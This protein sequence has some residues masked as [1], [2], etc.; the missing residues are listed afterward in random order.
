VFS[1]LVLIV[2][3]EC[4]V[5]FRRAGTAIG[6]SPRKLTDNYNVFLPEGIFVVGISSKL[7]KEQ[8][9]LVDNVG[10]MLPKKRRA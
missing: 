8:R 3:N 2:L 5:S 1:C 7:L 4:F 10:I 6:A 9:G